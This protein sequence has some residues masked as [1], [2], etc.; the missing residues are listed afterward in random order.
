MSPSR[1]AVTTYLG[2]CAGLVIIAMPSA[3]NLTVGVMFAVGQAARASIDSCVP[4]YAAYEATTRRINP[5]ARL[6]NITHREPST[7]SS[8]A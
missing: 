3:W 1:F 8:N 7:T 4:G 6:A 2:V 5:F